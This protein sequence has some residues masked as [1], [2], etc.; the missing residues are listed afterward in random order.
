MSMRF[1][2]FP[3]TK[4]KILELFGKLPKEPLETAP[5]TEQ[6]AAVYEAAVERF[7]LDVDAEITKLTDDEIHE[8]LGFFSIRVDETGCELRAPG[9]KP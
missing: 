5:S 7:W 8:A 1:D 2:L 9:P 3:N 4:L 6:S